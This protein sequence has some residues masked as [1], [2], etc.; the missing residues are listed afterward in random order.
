MLESKSEAAS[1]KSVSPKANVSSRSIQ[2][3]FNDDENSVSPSITP[4]V[5]LSVAQSMADNSFTDS[6]S[7]VTP[8]L[9]KSP[10]SVSRKM[11]SIEENR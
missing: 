7:T 4:S 2:S 11:T 8:G 6:K 9:D 1:V 5:T 10:R 3:A